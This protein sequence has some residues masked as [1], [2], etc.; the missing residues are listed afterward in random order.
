MQKFWQ[1]VREDPNRR[2]AAGMGWQMFRPF[3]QYLD[4][5]EAVR[6]ALCLSKNG[7][8][9]G[10]TYGVMEFKGAAGPVMPPIT[11]TDAE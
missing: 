11:W 7:G 1:V 8:T 3:V 2:D 5:K 4:E 6:A 10:I 9:T